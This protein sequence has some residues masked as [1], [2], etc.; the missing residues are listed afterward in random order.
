MLTTDFVTGSPNWLDLGSP[1][2]DAAAAFYGA[3]FGWEFRSAGPESGGYGFFQ[4]DGKTVGAVGPLTEEGAS[5]AWT[6]YFR[7][8]DADATAKAVE[9][10][11]GRV[12]SAPF[13]VF[14]AGRMA[15][16]TDPGGADF[17]VWQPAAVKGL[18]K[19]S[20]SDALCWAELHTG[21]PEGAFDFYRAVFGW[22]SQTMDVP[23]MTY[24]V[25]STGEGDQQDASFGGLAGLQG[26]AEETR[27]IPYFSVADVDET[28]A[29]AQGSG[30]SVLMPASDVP[31]VGRMGWLADPFGAP[32]AIIKP[33]P[34]Q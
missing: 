32:F 25:L 16:F 18:E 5:S 28:V 34:P 15:Q 6:V 10:H 2:I 4:K 33:E 3:V 17:A 14:E 24:T 23:G 12:R 13:D 21:D 30:G 26:D 7:T 9:Q 31:D 11:G 1:D 22:R 20:E 8:P 29:R 19:A 27:W